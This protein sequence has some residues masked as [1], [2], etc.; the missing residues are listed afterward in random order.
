ML[1]LYRLVGLALGK[2]FSDGFPLDASSAVLLLRIFSGRVV[3]KA[4]VVRS[5]AP[6]VFRLLQHVPEHCNSANIEQRLLAEFRGRLSSDNGSQSPRCQQVPILVE[7]EVILHRL[8][9]RTK[10]IQLETI[11]DAELSPQSKMEFVQQ[12]TDLVVERLV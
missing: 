3:D 12:A 5:V 2:A 4:A 1:A 10:F 6:S 7:R 8:A 9:H 11:G